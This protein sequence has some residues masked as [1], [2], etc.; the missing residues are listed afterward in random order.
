MNFIMTTT[1]V[2]QTHY[3]AS[4]TVSREVAGN[5]TRQHGITFAVL[6]MANAYKF[7]GDYTEGGATQVSLSPSNKTSYHKSPSCSNLNARRKKIC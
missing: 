5:L 2:Y 7:G 6:N 3:Y 1:L 4:F